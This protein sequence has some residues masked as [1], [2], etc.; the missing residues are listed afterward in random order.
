[1]KLSNPS[2]LLGLIVALIIIGVTFFFF[3]NQST[4]TRTGAE[5]SDV[6]SKQEGT[7]TASATT[8]VEPK[9]DGTETAKIASSAVIKTNRGEIEVSFFGAEAPKT[10]ENFQ[11]LSSAGFYTNTKF[12]RVIKGFMIQGGDPFTKD[13]SLK[14]QW[15]TG[16]P[17][18]TFEDEINAHKIVRGVLAMANAGPGTNGSQFFIVTAGATPWLDGAHTVF[19]KVVRGMDVVDAIEGTPTGERDIPK[20]PVVIESITMK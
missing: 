2:H 7:A 1:M 14:M 11:K 9:A 4:T 19:G 12:H 3:M 5:N 16:G 10:V 13:D 15:G 20:S 6:A 18:Y 17:G 8:G